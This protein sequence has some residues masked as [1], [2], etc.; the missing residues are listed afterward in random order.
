MF[1]PLSIYSGFPPIGFATCLPLS[2]AQSPDQQAGALCKCVKE[3]LAF[4]FGLGVMVAFI[5]VLALLLESGVFGH[6]VSA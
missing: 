4:Y 6:L 2:N 5:L 1:Q 3:R